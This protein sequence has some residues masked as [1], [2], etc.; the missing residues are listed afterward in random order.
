M[1]IGYARGIKEVMRKNNNKKDDASNLANNLMTQSSAQSINNNDGTA[2]RELRS[3]EMPGSPSNNPKLE[4]KNK[5]HESGAK[6]AEFPI[7][8][9]LHK[10][11]FGEMRDVDTS[12]EE[13]E[14]DMD[15]TED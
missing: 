5:S 13:E 7:S 9:S 10:D 1:L 8:P 4:S 6:S 15:C 3:S 2:N 12:S 11:L 14:D